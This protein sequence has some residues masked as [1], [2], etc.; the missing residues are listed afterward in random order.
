MISRCFLDCWRSSCLGICPSLP[1][2]A[3]YL[4]FWYQV[5]FPCW[6]GTSLTEG[7]P[8]LR[9][10]IETHALSP[11]RLHSQSRP[12]AQGSCS[13]EILWPQGE[14]RKRGRCTWMR[15]GMGFRRAPQGIATTAG[16]PE[17]RGGRG[18]SEFLLAEALGP[19]AN[20]PLLQ[21]MSARSSLSLAG[22]ECG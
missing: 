20:S 5:R 18:K 11:A 14:G 2:N 21:W 8:F 7:L 16:Q 4:I 3:L 6:A 12:S 17:S 19:G 13:G 15:A 9:Q 10:S 1:S 22:Q